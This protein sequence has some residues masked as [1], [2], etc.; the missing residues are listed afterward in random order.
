VRTQVPRIRLAA[1]VIAALAAAG[2]F[3]F[4]NATFGGPTLIPT[5]GTPYELRAS[6]ADSQNLVKNSLVMYRGFQVGLVDAVSI[7]HA[8]AQVTFKIFPQYAPLPAG[9]I[10]QVDHRTFLQEP[11]VNVYPGPMRGPKLRSGAL[12]RSVPTVEPDDALQVFDP[13]TRRL[14]D[15]GTQQLARGFRS[16]DAPM[17]VNAT[18]AA[19]DQVLGGIRQLTATLSG[20]EQQLSTLV[21]SSATVLNAIATQQSQLTQLIGSGATVAHTFASNA[22]AFGSGLD[23]LNGLLAAA[24]QLL[25]RVRPLL[26]TAAPIL[27]SAATTAGVLGPAIKALGPV[28]RSAR[29]TGVL[30]DPAARVA[31]PAFIHA[32]ASERWLRPLARG[33]V[34]AVA[35]LVPLMG[36]IRSQR[37]G[38]EAFVANLSDALSHGDSTG[39]WLQGFLELTNGA[40]TG[41]TAPCSSPLGLCVNPYPKPGDATDP[42]PYVRGQYPK[43]LPY[44]PSGPKP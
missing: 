7:V 8:R 40:L 9:T 42:Q 21:G 17:E 4:L 29:R 33:L 32:I 16:P 23:Q 3:L 25:P 44:F 2:L 24:N 14:L 22:T 11:F 1:F 19:L 38:W 20:Q 28:V 10:A 26:R 18:I 34:P 15:Q 43:L 36:Y 27:N 6:F 13:Q 5:A 37:R 39:P 12:V 30:L 31:V 35:N 41:G